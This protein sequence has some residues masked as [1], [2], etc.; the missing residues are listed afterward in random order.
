M[1]GSI[2]LTILVLMLMATTTARG[3]VPAQVR[4]ANE[5][6]EPGAHTDDLGITVGGLPNSHPGRRYPASHNFPTGPEVGE[7]LP[8]FSL[9]NQEGSIVDY[10]AD[11]GDSKSI[12][13]F[14]RSAVW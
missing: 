6:L 7:R 13:V 3:Q 10:H 14:Y 9:P 4:P 5:D 11:R 1:R 12:V 8:D 2:W